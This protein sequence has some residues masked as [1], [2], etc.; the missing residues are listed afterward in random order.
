MRGAADRRVL[1]AWG[2]RL[3]RPT[4]PWRAPPACALPSDSSRPAARMS[5]HPLASPARARRAAPA[6]ACLAAVAG[7]LALLAACT[8]GSGAR[9]GED[10]SAAGTAGTVGT[11]G[12]AGTVGPAPADS[13]GLVAPQARAMGSE[14][15]QATGDA[16]PIAAPVGIDTAAD[17]ITRGTALRSTEQPMQAPGVRPGAR[18]PR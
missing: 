11:V 10:A 9:E 5:T 2:M 3:G 6:P 4:V 1:P 7:A 15:A 13:T 16:S 8:G 17:T 14:A 18:R 12:T